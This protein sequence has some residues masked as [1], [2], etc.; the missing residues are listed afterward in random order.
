MK[1]VKGPEG[2]KRLA[3]TVAN[4][5]RGAKILTGEIKAGTGNSGKDK[6]LANLESLV[7]PGQANVAPFAAER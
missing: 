7:R 3:D 5:I 4:A 6:A 2:R 1:M